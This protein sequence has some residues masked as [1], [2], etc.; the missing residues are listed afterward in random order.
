MSW[1][2]R[3]LPYST[4]LVAALLPLAAGIYLLTSSCWTLAERAVLRRWA[5]GHR[6]TGEPCV[7]ILHTRLP[8]KSGRAARRPPM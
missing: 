2:G 3:L 1:L 8:N 5:R 6:V 4:L 7:Q